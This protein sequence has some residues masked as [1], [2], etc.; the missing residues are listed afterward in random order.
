MNKKLRILLINQL[1]HS[2]SS[3]FFRLGIKTC[4]DNTLH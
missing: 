4:Q 3:P 1:Y 2:V